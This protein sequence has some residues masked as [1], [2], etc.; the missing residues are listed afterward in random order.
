MIRVVLLLL[1]ALPAVAWSEGLIVTVSGFAS[2]Q[3]GISGRAALRARALDSAEDEALRRAGAD[4]SQKQNERRQ[5]FFKDDEE[6]WDRS[7]DRVT[8]ATGRYVVRL[9]KILEENPSE[10]EYAL[11]AV[12]E[13]TPESEV[14]VNLGFIWKNAGNPGIFL[15]LEEIQN[16]RTTNG[17]NRMHDYLRDSLTRQ[18]VSLLNKKTADSFRIHVS[19]STE[20]EQ[21]NVASVSVHTARC[22]AGFSI[23]APLDKEVAVQRYSRGRVPGFSFT[24][25][26]ESCYKELA[27]QLA[28]NIIR[29]LDAIMREYMEK[30]QDVSRYYPASRRGWRACY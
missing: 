8:R 21:N 22:R 24:A 23:Q 26:V 5:E 27:P 2:S 4:V 30:W 1:C 9:L 19:Q 12:Y 14:P 7:Y 10:K 3:D 28:E 18:G 17:K 15:S 6:S 11:R 20:V 16:G 25:A 13:V 29:S